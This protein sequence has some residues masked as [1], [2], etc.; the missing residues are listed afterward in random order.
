MKING[1]L[2]HSVMKISKHTSGEEPP[3]IIERHIKWPYQDILLW[4]T[5]NNHKIVALKNTVIT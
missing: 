3:L 1:F 2:N 5:V 4:N